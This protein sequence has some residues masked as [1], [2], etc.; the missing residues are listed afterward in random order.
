VGPARSMAAG[1][2]CEVL[3]GT[4]EQV[5]NAAEVGSSATSALYGE[6]SRGG[7]AVDVIEC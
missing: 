7:L 5:E 6:T 2:P 1:A 4:S 3:G